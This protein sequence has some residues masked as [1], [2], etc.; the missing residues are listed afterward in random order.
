[1][2]YFL[3]L[4]CLLTLPLK[5]CAVNKKV[6][7]YIVLS[8][9][10]S[11]A[12]AQ[13]TG[14]STTGRAATVAQVEQARLGSYVTLTGHVVAHQRSSYFTFRDGSGDIRVEIDNDVWNNRQVGPETKVRL[15]G[16]VDRGVAGRYIHVK[17][18]EIVK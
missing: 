1:M 16:E 9:A 18:L 7:A 15:L 14:P 3:R 8:V 13:F 17:S 4:S 12:A 5:D 2:L 10:A 11:T 6:L